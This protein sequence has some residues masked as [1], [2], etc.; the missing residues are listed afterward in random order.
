MFIFINIGLSYK[1]VEIS[2]ALVVD[3]IRIGR[4]RERDA[5]VNKR[6]EIGEHSKLSS[7][8][9]FFIVVVGFFSAPA[10]VFSS[11]SDALIDVRFNLICVQ[12]N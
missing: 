8:F 9:F 7:T 11:T 3:E 2:F 1:D 10:F 12:A 5:R 4:E 6:R